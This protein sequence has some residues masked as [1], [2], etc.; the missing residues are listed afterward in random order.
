M[1][2]NQVKDAWKRLTSRIEDLIDQ[3]NDL[4][5]IARNDYSN[6][7]VSYGYIG[8]D[9][10]LRWSVFYNLPG[11]SYSSYYGS[12]DTYDLDSAAQSIAFLNGM[13]TLL[14]IQKG[15]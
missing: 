9:D 1:P 11:T 10:D 8:N 14:K 4:S 15:L 6:R 13:V 2:S 7:V 12:Y 3:V 5:G